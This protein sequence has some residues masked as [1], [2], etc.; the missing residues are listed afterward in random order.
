[1]PPEQTSAP[2]PIPPPEAAK[3][4]SFWKRK[5]VLV[6]LVV[7]LVLAMADV[8]GAQ[9]YYRAYPEQSKVFEA[10]PNISVA[11]QVSTKY[12]YLLSDTGAKFLGTVPRTEQTWTAGNTPRVWNAPIFDDTNNLYYIATVQPDNGTYPGSGAVD[13]TGWTNRLVRISSDGTLTDVTT[14]GNSSTQHDPGIVLS[15]DRTLMAY[16]IRG[17]T[18]EVMQLS[19]KETQQYNA[20]VC[21]KA[22]SMHFSRDGQQILG[23]VGYYE[24]PYDYTGTAEEYR[25][26]EIKDGVGFYQLDLNTSKE[27]YLGPD[28]I[29]LNNVSGG[30][31][32][33]RTEQKITVK[34]VS[35]AAKDVL[36]SD[37]YSNLPTIATLSIPDAKMWNAY[38]AADGQGVYY[39]VIPSEPKN[40]YIL[41][42]YDIAQKKNYYP[43][44][45][46]TDRQPILLPPVSKNGLHYLATD[47]ST[48]LDSRG[49]PLDRQRLIHVSIEGSAEVVSEKLGNGYSQYVIFIAP[50]APTS[51]DSTV[52]PTTTNSQTSVA[53]TSPASGGILS[54]NQKTTMRWSV[55]QT[56]VSSFPSDFN[57]YL[58]T[59][60]EKQGD[61][62]G[63]QGA[64]INDGNDFVAG[65]AEWDIPGYIAHNQLTTGTYKIVWYL[66]ATPKDPARMCA[67][68]IGKDCSPNAADRAVM[69]RSLTYKG[70]TGWFEIK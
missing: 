43:L 8:I 58:F 36:T 49:Y 48:A 68:T 44:I 15:P 47:K 13:T 56:V 11:D 54:A 55:P 61:T 5:I 26:M 2:A 18:L 4:V 67:E 65:S 7:I 27:M 9:F 32:L 12:L 21:N 10:S 35:S 62:T 70:E 20:S 33:R 59:R 42:Y 6:P 53:I 1:M 28:A 39:F 41:G 25:Q 3:S 66:Q 40:N 17:K 51:H 29:V 31:E 23:Y 24:G 50:S 60:V 14:F 57:L 64:P 16:C 19:N 52:S 38:L 34:D 46:A 37:Q 45:T 63:S 30:R 69:Q 22:G